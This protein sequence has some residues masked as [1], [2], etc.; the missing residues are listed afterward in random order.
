MRALRG[1]AVAMAAALAMA[2][3]LFLFVRAGAAQ[4]PPSTRPESSG[5]DLVVEDIVLGPPNPHT[6]EPA[7]ITIT[8]RNRGD[9]AASGFRTYLYIDPADRPP[10]ITTPYATRWGYFLT[11]PPGATV[12]MSHGEHTFTEPG[13]NHVVYAW[14]DRDEQTVEGDET[15]NVQAITVCV[16]HEAVG[17]DDYEPDDTCAQVSSGS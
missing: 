10:T 11:F 6:Y 9:S 15:N 13:C 4:A 17:A 12:K 8:V 14:V 2:A 5:P 3:I 1:L 7:W 16:E